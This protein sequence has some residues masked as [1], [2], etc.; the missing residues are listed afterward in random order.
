MF[1][2]ASCQTKPTSAPQDPTIQMPSSSN[3]QVPAGVPETVNVPQFVGQ[4]AP[5]VGLIFGPGG[6]KTLAQIGVLQEIEKNKLPVVAVAGLEWGALVGGLFALSGQIHEMDWKV[7][8][9]PKATFADKGLFSKK[10][11]PAAN[12]DYDLFLGKVFTDT[13]IEQ[14]KI[15]FACPYLRAPSGRVSLATKGSLKNSMRGC[16]YFPPMFQ[17]SD[18]LA[19]PFALQESVQFLKSAG[20]ELIVLVNV[21]DNVDKK[22]F[23]DWDDT[24]GVWLAWSAAMQSLKNA[25]SSG[26]HEVISIDTSSFKMTDTDQRL[27]LIQLGKQSATSQLEQ[28][29]KKYDF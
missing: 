9:L 23:A 19:A 8:Q 3:A 15:P 1:L 17:H 26:V 28:I 14:T 25:K 6:A 2:A 29:N 21:L 27:R 12:K 16:W 10:M 5:R 7:S 18:V 13:R 22:Q 4:R 24:D 11:N 20:A